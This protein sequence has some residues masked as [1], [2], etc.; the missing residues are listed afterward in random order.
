MNIKI[1][2]TGTSGHQLVRQK[3]KEF[4]NHA[5]ISY[6]LEDIGDVSKFIRDNVYSVPAIKIDN[7]TLYEI[8]PNGSFNESL[9]QAIQSILRKSKY[10]N[11]IKII[12]PTDFS[13]ASLN[14]Y[15]FARGL[16]KSLKGVIYLTHVYFP[17]SAQLN[18][19]TYTDADM[20]VKS[21]KKLDDLVKSVNQDWIGEFVKEP[22][23][24][25]R[26]EVGF[27]VKELVQMSEEPNTIM[28]M[29]STGE[30]DQFKKIFGSLSLDLLRSAK[31]P[32]YLIPKDLKYQATSNILFCSEN[33]KED[34]NAIIS[35]GKVCVDTHKKLHILHVVSNA[36]A[37]DYNETLL[38]DLIT[39]YYPELEYA[40]FVI[41]APTVKAGLDKAIQTHPYELLVFNT[42][43]R[44][45]FSE[46]FH[47][48]VTEHVALYYEK[49]VLIYHQQ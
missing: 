44:N 40:I 11:M 23:V 29:G 34:A 3:I 16:A 47:S 9:R 8:K 19:L 46:I 10:G 38:R 26:F 6:I 24:E 31:C 45:F 22:M 28:V 17:T 20:E 5:G 2:G 36:L 35:A 12:V 18:E 43:H 37:D 49:A 13:E 14:A 48:S 39:K 33:L 41:H 21:R 4:L 25:A 30:G 15:N 32:L 27:P 42:K 7:E 1:Y